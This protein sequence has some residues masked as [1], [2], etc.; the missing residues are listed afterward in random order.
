MALAVAC[1][2]LPDRMPLE[3]LI[4]V[5]EE[6]GL[7]GA[8]ELD[9]SLVKGKH[10][11]NLDSE[12]DWLFCIG[13][14]GGVNLTSAFPHASNHFSPKGPFWSIWLT[15][16]RGGHSGVQINE[17]RTNAIVALAGFLQQ[18]RSKAPDLTLHS[19]QGGNKRNAIPRETQV[20]ISG[21][22]QDLLESII[23]DYREM[24]QGNEPDA[25]ITCEAVSDQPQTTLPF[26]LLDFV[27]EV[28][29]GVIGMSADFPDLV[30]TSSN[31]SI[32]ETHDT[33]VT[34]F[35][36]GRSSVNADKEE[37]VAHVRD[38]TM[39]NN[40]IF[41]RSGDYPGWA[42]TP[43][44]LLLKHGEGI[45]EE[46]F[47]EKAEVVAIHA[48]LEAGIIGDKLE[49]DQLLAYGPTILNPHSPDEKVNIASV[50]KAWSFMKA[51]VSR[52]FA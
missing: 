26:A 29:Q 46:L 31:V 30:Q 18:L 32:I 40:G 48:G 45:Y 15:G 8:L 43:N 3:I 51:F 10:V 44:S 41:S 27:S 12:E 5:D 16:C 52:P 42:P 20:V 7:N 21:V 2:E 23:D 13:C 17:G 39:N 33:G 22:S 38:L 36:L 19:W 35:M 24:L 4:T 25:E 34:V 6:T 49:T 9:P 28:P 50:D 11:L 14:A 47:G 1:E 37:M